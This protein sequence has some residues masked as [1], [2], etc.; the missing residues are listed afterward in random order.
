MWFAD[1]S[2]Q[3]GSIARAVETGT[4][5]SGLGALAVVVVTVALVVGRDRHGG[6]A[7]RGV[8]AVLAVVQGKRVGNAAVA[9]TSHLMAQVDMG[10]A[11]SGPPTG[12]GVI[13]PQA[14]SIACMAS[15]LGQA[16]QCPG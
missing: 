3:V 9:G 16:G 1:T 10:A 7:G 14:M 8:L 11:L 5:V 6:R 2:F 15:G 13:M 4:V 12:I